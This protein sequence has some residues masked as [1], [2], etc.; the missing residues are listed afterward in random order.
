[1]ADHAASC[2]GSSRP[3]SISAGTSSGKPSPS[4]RIRAANALLSVS[5]ADL[6]CGDQPRTD[7]DLEHRALTTARLRLPGGGSLGVAVTHLDHKAEAL[8][9]P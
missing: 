7:S 9:L 1:M 2:D 5:P 4:S 3:S 6:T 8:T